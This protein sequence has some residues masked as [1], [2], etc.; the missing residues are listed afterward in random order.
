MAVTGDWWVTPKRRFKDLP[1]EITLNDKIEIFYERID[2]WKFDIADQLING[3]VV[4]DERGNISVEG[5]PHA[6]YAVL[7]IVLSYFEMI[8]KYADGYLDMHE[9]EPY[10]KKGVRMVFPE[11]ETANQDSVETLLDTLYHG[12]RCGLYHVGLTYTNIFLEGGE[13]PPISF[14]S[15]G[16]VYLNP[17]KL[18]QTMRAHFNSYINQLRDVNNLDLRQNFEK[19]FDKDTSE[20]SIGDATGLH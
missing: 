14:R 18:V 2:G 5:S 15:N 7:N 6:A 9:S 3:R 4:K 13:A 19:R 8:A 16:T 20:R 11:S 10:F 12:A 17:H 1:K